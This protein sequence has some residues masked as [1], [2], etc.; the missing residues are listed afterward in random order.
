MA[1]VQRVA[2]GP[3]GDKPQEWSNTASGAH[4]TI[5]SSRAFKRGDVECREIRGENTA[6]GRTLPF[7]G[8]VCK[9]PTGKWLISQNPSHNQP[10]AAPAPKVEPTNPP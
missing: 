7:R 2:D 4:G 1:T 9:D 6:R 10:P 3:V 8:T 5:R